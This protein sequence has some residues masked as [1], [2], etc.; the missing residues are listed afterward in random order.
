MYCFIKTAQRATKNHHDFSGDFLAPVPKSIKAGDVYFAIANGTIGAG[1]RQTNWGRV[2]A[3]EMLESMLRQLK[4]NKEEP[5]QF[6][7]EDEVAV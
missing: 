7:E 4:N 2:Q 6:S 1:A 5:F 3:I